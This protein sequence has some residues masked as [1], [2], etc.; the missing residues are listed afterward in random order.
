MIKQLKRITILKDLKV[1]FNR[2][3]L[4]SLCLLEEISVLAFFLKLPYN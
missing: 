2:A 3:H 1:T 4:R